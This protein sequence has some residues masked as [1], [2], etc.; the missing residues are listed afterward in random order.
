MHKFES[1]STA[2][3]AA[4]LIVAPLLAWAVLTYQSLQ[5]TGL[6]IAAIS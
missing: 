6:M 3:F 1:V 2:L 5:A 4:M